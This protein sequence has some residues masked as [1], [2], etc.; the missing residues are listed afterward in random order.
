MIDS[1]RF[2]NI[3][4]AASAAILLSMTMPAPA[5]ADPVDYRVYAGLLEKYVHGGAVD[6]A[7]FQKEYLA[8][9]DFLD[10]LARVDVSTLTRNEQLA[11]YINVYNA[12]TIKL[13]A[14][15]YPNLR[16][17]KDV[18]GFLGLTTWGP[19]G[20]PWKLEIV[21]LKGVNYTLDQIEHDIIRGN[22]PGPAH[23]FRAQSRGPGLSAAFVP[24]VSRSDHRPAA[25]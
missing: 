13:I 9:E 12:W 18:K 10:I 24:A 17:I 15:K 23:S 3:F 8:F 16:S 14:M 21:R 25:R 7:G 1:K 6:Y 22:V 4:A 19:F 5:A 11:F 20:S 2:R